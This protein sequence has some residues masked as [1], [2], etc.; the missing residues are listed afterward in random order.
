VTIDDDAAVRKL[1]MRA[2]ILAAAPD[3]LLRFTLTKFTMDEVARAAGIAR[4]TIYKHFSSRD[5][6]LI[7]MLIEDMQVRQAP[8][9][10]DV[11]GR[12]PSVENLV[13]IFLT[14]LE[15]AAK[16]PLFHELLD[17]R[18]APR[19]AELLFQSASIMAVREASWKP[20][21]HRY[22]EQGVVRSD[23]DLAATVRWI[24]YQMFWL[25]THPAVLTDDTAEL[26][27]YV[28]RYILGGIVA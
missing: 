1:P 23:L 11:V 19:A 14:E 24:T 27:E 9:L 17:P 21:L 12:H 22:A 16:Y 26:R 18:T 10:R 7:A 15:V 4:Q 5:E 20:I 13:E 2:R 6:L 8:E 28:R 3:V 25:V